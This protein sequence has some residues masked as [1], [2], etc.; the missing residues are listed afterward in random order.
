[1]FLKRLAALFYDSLLIA[2]L[3]LMGTVFILFFTFGKPIPAGNYYYQAYL[4]FIV[5]CFYIWFWTHGGQTAGMAAWRLK[6]V[7]TSNK[8]MTLYRALLRAL[9]GPLSLLCGGIGLLWALF[10]KEKLTLYDRLSQT[11]IISVQ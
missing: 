4:F 10:D 8:P 7:T 9:I 2:A 5:L 11:R 6:L 1:M 3:L